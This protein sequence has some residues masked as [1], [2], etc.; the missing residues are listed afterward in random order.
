[1]VG[2][3]S[4]IQDV[5]RVALVFYLLPMMLIGC[6]NQELKVRVD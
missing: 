1:V 2:L 5:P 6:K 4:S 3:V